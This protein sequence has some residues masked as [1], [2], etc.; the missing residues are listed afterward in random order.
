MGCICW[1]AVGA[2]QCTVQ[3]CMCIWGA[4]AA[5][6]QPHLD[7]LPERLAH[8]ASGIEIAAVVMPRGD[9]GS[10]PLNSVGGA[11]LYWQLRCS[12]HRSA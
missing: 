8:R 1:H 4:L 9:A 12:V 2:L 3:C 11:N 5:R 10:G 7:Q 6:G